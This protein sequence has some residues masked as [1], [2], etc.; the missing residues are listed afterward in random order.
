MTDDEADECPICDEPITADQED[1]AHM[2][3]NGHMMHD[4]CCP[5]CNGDP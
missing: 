3:P 4:W 2:D 5:E 1:D